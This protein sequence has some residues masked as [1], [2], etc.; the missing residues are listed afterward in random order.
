MQ[1]F[2]STN[3]VMVWPCA[4]KGTRNDNK[5]DDG[6]ETN[7]GETERKTQDKIDRPGIQR[8]KKFRNLRMAEWK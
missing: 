4:K 6:L 7:S 8:Y 1:I 5:E 3:I 2:D